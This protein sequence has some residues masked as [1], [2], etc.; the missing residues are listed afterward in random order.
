[1][2]T[3]ELT[4]IENELYSAVIE[5]YN[6]EQTSELNNR[7]MDIF[8]S[9]RQVH[10]DYS[11]LSKQN[12]EALKRGLFIQ[13]YALTEPSYLTGIENIDQDA[14]AIIIDTIE[15]RICNNTLDK[16][17][18]WMLNYYA[19]WDFVFDR[20][21]NRKGLAQVLANK[22]DYLFPTKVDRESMKKRG[23]MGRY[24]NSLARLAK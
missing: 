16:E 13:W 10:I 7:L 9:Y 24:W 3:E 23:Q 17:L 22:T 14:E 20:F 12:D 15:E 1:M 6:Q 11:D 2:T 19:T 4:K 8:I 18:K 21:K 5:I